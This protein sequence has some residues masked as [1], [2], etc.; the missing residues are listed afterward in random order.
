MRPSVSLRVRYQDVLTSIASAL[1]F[2]S[3]LFSWVL[4][5]RSSSGSPKELRWLMEAPLVQR[6]RRTLVCEAASA[7]TVQVVTKVSLA[8]HHHT[9]PSGGVLSPFRLLSTV[10]KNMDFI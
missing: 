3:G 7:K 6:R 10:A 2:E 9:T 8:H 5:P 4:N 1:E